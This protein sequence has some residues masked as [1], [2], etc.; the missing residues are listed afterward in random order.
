MT[1]EDYENFFVFMV[2]DILPFL[3]KKNRKL[4]NRISILIDFENQDCQ[5]SLLKI[6]LEVSEDHYL[7]VVHRIFIVNLNLQ[8]VS[9]EFV[10]IVK[11][12]K[13]KELI[14]IFDKNYQQNLVK[15]IRGDQY[16]CL[17]GGVKKYSKSYNLASGINSFDFQL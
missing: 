9:T 11:G 2:E 8:T 14:I 12:C 10:D 5:P 16:L 1:K 17:Y 13:N 6:L 7:G 3:L 4:W 15:Y